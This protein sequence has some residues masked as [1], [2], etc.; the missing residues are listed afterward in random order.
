MRV[1]EDKLEEC[2][3]ICEVL[4]AS[5]NSDDAKVLQNAASVAIE[6]CRLMRVSARESLHELVEDKE[7]E[8]ESILLLSASSPYADNLPPEVLERK[9]EIEIELKSM[10]ESMSAN[11]KDDSEIVSFKWSSIRSLLK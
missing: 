1:G 5:D 9:R 6:K 4:I 8:E 10:R 7:K 11:A 2:A 3:E